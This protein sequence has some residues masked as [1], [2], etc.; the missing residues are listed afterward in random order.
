MG[1]EDPE[2]VDP[3]LL[4]EHMDWVQGLARRLVEDETLADDI[5][6]DAWAIAVASPPRG[7]ESLRGWLATVV[8]NLVRR[9]WRL[10]SRRR[11]L[12]ARG[13]APEA[14]A[15][16]GLLAERVEHQRTL[17][18]LLLE[19]P[20][21][22]RDTLLLRYYERASHE[23]I[24]RRTGVAPATVRTRLARGLGALRA[25]IEQKHGRRGGALLCLTAAGPRRTPGGRP[26]LGWPLPRLP[27][28]VPAAALAVCAG[29]GLWISLAPPRARPSGVGRVAATD[30][31][32][33]DARLAPLVAAAETR[34][35]RAPARGA[36]ASGAKPPAAPSDPQPSVRGRVVD[37]TGRPA[38]G[39]DVAFVPAET[40][41]DVAVPPAV[42]S[43]ADGSFRIALPQVD[44][45]LEARG[46]GLVSVL[47]ALVARGHRA[48][49]FEVTL[50]VAAAGPL[51]GRVL[52]D[53]GRPV[54]GAAVRFAYERD[55]RADLG[56]VLHGS[57][58]SR[59]ET[60]SGPDG[61]FRFERAPLDE[62]AAITVEKVSFRSA[63]ELVGTSRREEVE[64]RL[65]PLPSASGGA[66]RTGRVVDAAGAPA[67]FAWIAYAD[68]VARCDADG[69]FQLDTAGVEAAEWLAVRAGS[70]PARR[71]VGPDD[72]GD[73]LLLVLGDAPLELSGTVVDATGVPLAGLTVRR[74]DGEDFGLVP[75]FDGG[76]AFRR[77]MHVEELASGNAEGRSTSTGAEGRFRL[78]GLQRR[79]YRLL[80]S[81]PKTLRLTLTRPLTPGSGAGVTI[82]LREDG[83]LAPRRGRLVT[84]AGAPI[85]GLQVLAGRRAPGADPT[86]PPEQWTAPIRTDSDGCFEFPALVRGDLFLTTETSPAFTRQSWRLRETPDGRGPKYGVQRQCFFQIAEAPPGADG[87]RV[88]D[89]A[90]QL[91]PI[92]FG[93]GSFQRMSAAGPVSDAGRSDVVGV[94]ETAARVVLYAGEERLAEAPLELAPDEVVRADR[95]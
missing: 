75:D 13:A 54:A 46:E 57:T 86:A 39:V 1:S 41:T 89:G 28:V 88:F 17:V 15:G 29:A 87:F 43:D 58:L 24:A 2:R 26:P 25:R 37:P 30:E 80:V 59:W 70:L 60:L 47:G 63:L 22:Y 83:E 94:Q 35:E 6:Q 34:A 56:R 90:G 65:E 68:K 62:L 74:V 33:L 67:P 32:P 36:P 61:G 3:E 5:S 12:E 21:A 66:V 55:F 82:E 9:A 16:P 76:V 14:T 49:S 72:R 69:R 19:L 50:V 11:E 42:V 7:P 48:P 73:P 23:E 20:E 64:I 38:G 53:A 85:A 93:A 95:W 79:P 44:G 45:E 40:A 92:T 10:E 51:S 18:G 84:L 71:P 31:A 27:R 77:R 52:D 81:D 78:S 8:R 4:L 91:V